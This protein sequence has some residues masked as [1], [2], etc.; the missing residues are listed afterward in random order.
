MD[1]SARL[2]NPYIAAERGYIDAVIDPADTAERFVQHFTCSVT[3]VNVWFLANTTTPRCSCLFTRLSGFQRV[4]SPNLTAGE[5][6]LARK[7][8]SRGDPI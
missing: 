7:N 1:Y 3:N 4:G 6:A 5:K 2:L 8:Y